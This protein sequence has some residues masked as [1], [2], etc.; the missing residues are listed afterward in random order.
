M[1]THVQTPLKYQ[2]RYLLK[3]KYTTLTTTRLSSRGYA[4]AIS[5]METQR[6]FPIKGFDSTRMEILGIRTTKTLATRS[7]RTPHQEGPKSL[8]RVTQAG[9]AHPMAT[10][11]GTMGMEVA[12]TRR[13]ARR[14]AIALIA[15][16]RMRKRFLIGPRHTA[17]EVTGRGIHLD[18]P[19][20]DIPLLHV[21]IPIGAKNPYDPQNT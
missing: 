7:E 3:R 4:M 5:G 8:R 20:L 6:R 13:I 18:D 10:G 9:T 11:Q 15:L 14:V 19:R 16:P 12:L 17:D 1:V 21:P 2:S